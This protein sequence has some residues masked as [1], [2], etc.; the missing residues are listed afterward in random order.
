MRHLAGSLLPAVLLVLA[1]GCSSDDETGSGRAVDSG[2]A[3]DTGGGG[4]QDTGGAGVEDSGG[5]RAEDAGGGGAGDTGGEVTDS[6][7]GGSDSGPDGGGPED[8]FGDGTRWEAFDASAVAQGFATR[9]YYGAVS[10]GRHIYYVPCRMAH[11]HGFVMRFDTEGDFQAPESWQAYDASSTGGMIMR[12]FAGGV[13]DGRYIYFV[14]YANDVDQMERHARVLR[15]D[16]HGAFADAASW[17][18][19]DASGLMGIPT[20]RAG[21]LGYDGAVY[22]GERYVYLVPYGDQQ[23][24][25]GF[26]LRY[27]T[28]DDPGFDQAARWTVFNVQAVPGLTHKGYYGGTFD[29]RYVYYV[30]FADGPDAFHGEVLRYDSQ[31]PFDAAESWASYDAS[32][33]GEGATVGYKGAT[34]DGRYVYFVPFRETEQQQHSRVLRYDTQRSFKDAASWAV[35]DATGTD[36]L[37]TVGFVGAEYD[38]RY[39]YFVPYTQQ[40]NVYHANVLRYDTQ[41]SF[42]E[43]ASWRA[44]DADGTG[45]LP[46]RGYK[47]GVYHEPYLYFA[48]YNNTAAPRDPG[49][50]DNFHGIALRYRVR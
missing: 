40:G 13:F 31:A 14:P 1:A 24:A 43:G 3:G 46:T 34:F 42:Q 8:G 21:L 4:G 2:V 39:V 5:A 9:G 17:A 12:G 48:P 6:G 30:P 45:G 26:A 35:H 19:Y 27:D 11:F 16:T 10:D 15:Y 38:G 33:A 22:D 47:Y 25:H 32:S 36:G 44:Y 20:Q 7:P 41:G 37:Q 18:A 49:H 50:N 23:A 28:R 29:G